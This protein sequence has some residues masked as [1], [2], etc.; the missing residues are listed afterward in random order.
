MH[1]RA[2]HSTHPPT[3]ASPTPAAPPP[4]TPPEPALPEPASPAADRY[5][6]HLSPAAE[7]LLAEAQARRARDG[8]DSGEAPLYRPAAR[9]SE[10]A[11]A[12][13]DEDRRQRRIHLA[14]AARR[15]GRRLGTISTR[16]WGAAPSPYLRLSGQWLRDAGFQMGQHF[17]VEVGEERLTIEAV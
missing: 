12:V 14:R 10:I 11:E 2:K 6:F 7:H 4:A 17:E 5:V 13:T 15:R 9:L 16:S 1:G 8:N 3:S